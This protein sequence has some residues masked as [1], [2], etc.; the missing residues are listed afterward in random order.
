MYHDPLV[1][2]SFRRLYHAA[3]WQFARRTFT[4]WQ[5][6]GFH[7]T[8]NHYYEPIPDTSA[9]DEAIWERESGMVG[10][11]WH[12]QRQRAFLD[13]VCS[14]YKSEFDEFELDKPGAN[15]RY[16][17]RN[18]V[19]GRMDGDVLYC[20]I[21]H[22][23]PRTVIEV[24][25][26]WSTFLSACALEKNRAEDGIPTRLV[27]IEPF[28]TPTLRQG[29]GGNVELVEARLQDVDLDL[30]QTLEENDILFLD[31]THVVKIDSDVCHEYLEILPRL[32]PGVLVH[33]HD[34]Y[35]PD[36][37][38]KQLVLGRKIFWNE[39]Y[40]LQAFLAFNRA[41]EILW[42]ANYMRSRYPQDCSQV[43]REPA[44]SSF[45]LRRVA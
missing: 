3:I 7:L 43:F 1:D 8:P 13:A 11:D 25:S 17:G 31:S 23:R 6:L 42:A 37:Y 16:F 12:P 19:F 15:C 44:G 2:M 32:Q 41:F 14:R 34:I 45:W 20:M 21:R 39:A 10:L 29:I 22:Y 26:G 36:E 30:F 5:R 18:G 24:G 35:L 9:L 4:L 33:I 40:L 38:P 27:A 28:P